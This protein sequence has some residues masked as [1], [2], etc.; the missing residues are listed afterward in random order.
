MKEINLEKNIQLCFNTGF[1]TLVTAE[2]DEDY[3]NSIIFIHN[4][5]ELLM[6]YY[7][8]RKDKWLIYPKITSNML[9]N[10]RNDLRKSVRLEHSKTI[11]FAKCRRILEHFSE[12]TEKNANYLTQLDYKRNSCVHFEFS[13]DERELRKLLFVHIYQFIYDLIIEMG[14]DLNT[15]I[16]ESN[17]GSLN[18][19]KNTIDNQ[20]KQNYYAKIASARKH[21]SEELLENDRIQKAETEDYTKKR[22]DMIVKCPA[23]R[24]NA[25]LRRKIQHTHGQLRDGYMAIKRDLLLR[26]LSCHYCGL[27]ITDYDQLELIFK[28]K[29][30]SLQEIAYRIPYDCPEDCPDDCREY[31]PSDCREYYPIVQNTLLMIAGK[32]VQNTLLMIA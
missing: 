16:P 25:L 7:L 5:L 20:I 4:G 30:E 9:L 8:R 27:N 18:N 32:I 21:Y 17:R 11:S 26:D 3:R 10:K 1:G 28:D 6:K 31:Y 29:E 2:T 23:C 19:Y 12:L 13:Y 22:F 24:K 15:F 14:L